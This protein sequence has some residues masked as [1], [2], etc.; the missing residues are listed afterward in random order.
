MVKYR[1]E[2]FRVLWI[3]SLVLLGQ[4]GRADSSSAFAYQQGMEAVRISDRGMKLF[5]PNAARDGLTQGEPRSLRRVLRGTEWVILEHSDDGASLERIRVSLIDRKGPSRY[6]SGLEFYTRY[7]WPL[8]VNALGR[9]R[10]VDSDRAT[11]LSST[12]LQETHSP[13]YGRWGVVVEID[14]TKMGLRAD[15]VNSLISS[16]KV[17]LELK[18]EDQS[19][20][21][22]QEDETSKHS[23]N[24]AMVLVW[25]NPDGSG[26]SYIHLMDQ[27]TRAE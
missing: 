6:W 24:V 10:S 27:W 23:N 25:E 7:R 16:P 1:K 14:A 2:S 11:V 12:P 21:D 20:G 15:T 8:L 22:F 4:S 3:L 17:H 5:L 19:P 18:Y 26:N 9:I 13:S